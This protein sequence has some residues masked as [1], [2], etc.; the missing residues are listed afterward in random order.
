MACGRP[1]IALG[2]GGAT[3]TVR[4]GITGTLVDV[5]DMRVDAF[6]DAMDAASRASFDPVAIRRQAEQFSEDRF[7]TGFRDALHRLVEAPA[8]C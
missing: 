7:E 5:D 1:V 6:A 3:E 4:H 2:R 8:S